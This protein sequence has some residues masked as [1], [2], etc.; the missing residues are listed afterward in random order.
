MWVILLGA[1][2]TGFCFGIYIG[3]ELK[4]ERHN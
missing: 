2:C 4:D 3:E 1:V